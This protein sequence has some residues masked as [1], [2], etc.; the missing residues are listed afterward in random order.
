MGEED[1]QQLSFIEQNLSSV[2]QQRQSHQKHILEIE[3]AISE[4]E[5]SDE[6]Y[7]IV[8]SIMVKKSSED[9]KSSL[10]EKKKIHASRLSSLEKQEN[11]LR[12][13]AKE[14]QEKVMANLEE[15]E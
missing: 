4:L 9:I 15:K 5:H 10:E 6:G 2:V 8:G 13:K 7:E 1:I 3:N 12:D 14:L 11:S